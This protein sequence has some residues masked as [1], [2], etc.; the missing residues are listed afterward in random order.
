MIPN[1][2]F[3]DKSKRGQAKQIRQ[4]QYRQVLKYSRNTD[5]QNETQINDMQVVKFSIMTNIIGYESAS[6][7]EIVKIFDRT[8]LSILNILK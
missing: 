7:S 4:G 5:S 2:I 1:Q 8:F 3:K 6:N